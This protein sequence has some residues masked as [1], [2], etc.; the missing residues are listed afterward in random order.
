MEVSPV[1]LIG[2]AQ[3]AEMHLAVE[4]LASASESCQAADIDA[5]VEH[6]RQH[7]CWPALVVLA[8]TWPGQFTLR[9][10]ERLRHAVPLARIVGLL[11]AWCEGETRTGE[12][13]PGVT[14]YYWHQWMARFARELREAVSG[15]LPAWALS[16]TISEEERWLSLSSG[17]V[18]QKGIVAIRATEPE[19]A[20]WLAAACRREGFDT[21]GVS[22]QAPERLEGC[23]AVLW[24]GPLET[25]RD[26]AELAGWARAIAPAPVMAL[27][28]FPRLDDRETALRAGAAAVCSKP[29]PWV[30]LFGE[31]ERLLGVAANSASTRFGIAPPTL[32]NRPRAT[33]DP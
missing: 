26:E 10:V 9:D 1:L 5:A 19:V 29:L 8:Q 25:E 33:Y 32:D 11:G 3:Q 2:D 6:I 17:Q 23:L 14:R 21:I 22:G 4:A 31:L 28:D 30:D 20:G 27:L 24:D 12:P 16:P 18:Q 15:H 7:E 13:W